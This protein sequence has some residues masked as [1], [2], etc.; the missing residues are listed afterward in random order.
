MKMRLLMPVIACVLCAPLFTPAASAQTGTMGTRQMRDV[1]RKA[2]QKARH[3]QS[4][5]QTAASP[6]QKASSAAPASAP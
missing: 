5:S 6:H 4:A 2:E 1:Q 3:N